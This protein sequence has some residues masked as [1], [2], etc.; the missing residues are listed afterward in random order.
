[1]KWNRVKTL[2]YIS[3]IRVEQQ[4]VRNEQCFINENISVS[5]NSFLQSWDMLNVKI[6]SI[7]NTEFAIEYRI[8]D[9]IPNFRLN[10]KHAR[11]N[12]TSTNRHNNRILLLHTLVSP[13]YHFLFDRT[14]FFFF[15]YSFLHSIFYKLWHRVKLTR[16]TL[17][18]SLKNYRFIDHF[19]DFGLRRFLISAM[20]WPNSSTLTVSLFRERWLLGAITTL[21]RQYDSDAKARQTFGNEAKE[22]AKGLADVETW[23][24]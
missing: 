5:C 23:L 22:L 6:F 24:F 3:R 19:I 11:S 13:L 20:Q 14:K 17:N 4:K 7:L 1:M 15:L 8:R 21:P 16:V 10:A 2:A 12:S 9:W 18:R